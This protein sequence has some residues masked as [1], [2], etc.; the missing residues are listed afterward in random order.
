MRQ[1]DI[2][3]D[4]QYGDIDYMYAKK[5]FTYDTV[6]YAGLPAYVQELKQQGTRFVIILDPGILNTDLPGVYPPLDQGNQ[7]GIWV[8][9]ADGTN[10]EGVVWPGPV[11]YPDF[12]NPDTQIW[13]TQQSVDFMQLVEYAALW[14]DM[15]EPSNFE[16]GNGGGCASNP[17]NFP[18]YVPA[19][20]DR[21]MFAKTICP[22]SVQAAGN[23]YD[24]HSLYG[25]SMS[26]QTLPAVRTATGKRSMAFSRSTFPGSGSY[27]QHWLGDNFSNFAALGYSLIG[28]MEFNMFG[29]PYVG[30]D[31]CGFIGDTTEQL[32]QRWQQVGAF[33]PFAR[34]HNSQGSIAQDPGMWPEVARVTRDTLRIRYTLLPFLY[35]LMYK[36]HSEGSTVVRPLFFEFPSDGTTYSIDDQILWGSALLISPVLTQDTFS[37]N[38]YFPDSKW[39][40]Y[41]DG[42]LAP[43]RASFA[44][45][46]APL[47]FISLHVR[48]G[49]ILPT[50]QPANSTLF[51]RTLPMGLIVALDDVSQANGD[52]FWDDGESNAFESGAYY[53]ATYSVEAGEL[54]SAIQHNGYSG[55]NSL[56]IGDVRVFGIVFTV[57]QVTVNSAPYSSWSQNPVTGELTISAL[58]LPLS[59]T[60]SIQ[61]S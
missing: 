25:W 21:N 23:L 58:N 54:S 43:G 18:P 47:D 41:Y 28:T 11:Y 53:F 42:S 57:S 6:N 22:D 45:V 2:P 31:I 19:I 10:A 20:L 39:Y 32:C 52:L 59:S 44:T 51:S 30:P 29:Y 38:A 3:H 35:T 7:L 37:V 12:T 8:K 13:M 14:I 34:N 16:N 17:L 36:A 24:V 15:N 9:N 4:V 40:S 61:W 46:D 50:Q 48:G 5:D 1:Y 60:F 49:S 27:A 56:F 26:K 33:Y 55:V